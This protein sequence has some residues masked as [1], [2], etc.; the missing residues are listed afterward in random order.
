MTVP[1]QGRFAGSYSGGDVARALPGIESQFLRHAW[2][3]CLAYCAIAH[4]RLRNGEYN[5][6]G[7]M[8]CFMSALAQPKAGAD[9]PLSVG[10]ASA[11]RLQIPGKTRAEVRIKA[12]AR[13]LQKKVLQTNLLSGH[14]G[15]ARRHQP[16]E[17]TPC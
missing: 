3:E 7:F 16:L 6:V 14:G 11:L 2:Q 17:S 13:K 10:S 12:W 4:T 1:G 5:G 15:L 9:F 8:N